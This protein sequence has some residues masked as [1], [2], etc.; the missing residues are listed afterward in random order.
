[1]FKSILI[2]LAF[3]FGFVSLVKAGDLKRTL[4]IIK[5]AAM[6]IINGTWNKV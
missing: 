5:G 6:N 4:P 3:A 1:M 2:Y